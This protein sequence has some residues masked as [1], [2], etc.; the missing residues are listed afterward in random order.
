MSD[1]DQEL[2]TVVRELRDLQQKTLDTQRQ[3]QL[4]MLPIFVMLA[5][6]TILGITGFLSH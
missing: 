1:K 3:Q 5:I 2:L 6:A 4:L